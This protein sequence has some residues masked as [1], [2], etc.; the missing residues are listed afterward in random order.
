[1]TTT[2]SVPA[3]GS[4]AARCRWRPQILQMRHISCSD[5]GGPTA[6]LDE[7]AGKSVNKAPELNDLQADSLLMLANHTENNWPIQRE[8]LLQ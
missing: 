2:T 1:M 3:G 6:E 5:P 8:I 4:Q 7:E